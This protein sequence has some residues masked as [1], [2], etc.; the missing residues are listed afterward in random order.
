M[1]IYT[2]MVFL[3]KMKVKSLKKKIHT[4]KGVID[5]EPQLIE[6]SIKK[7]TLYDVLLNNANI[8][9]KEYEVLYE[10]GKDFI[11]DGEMDTLLEYLLE[12]QVNPI[13]SGFNYSMTDIKNTLRH[14]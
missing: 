1:L 13:Y 7:Y 12:N 4:K 6:A 3:Q 14:L 10:K 9:Q 5:K 2:N 8:N 11:S